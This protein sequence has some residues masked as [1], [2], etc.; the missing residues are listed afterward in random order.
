MVQSWR[1][2]DAMSTEREAQYATDA[3]IDHDVRIEDGSYN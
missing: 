2:C 1:Q 3:V